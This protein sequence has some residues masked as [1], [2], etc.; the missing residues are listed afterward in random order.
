VYTVPPYL[1]VL[2]A[3]A[4]GLAQA[5]GQWRALTDDD[6]WQPAL[7]RALLAD[8]AADGHQDIGRAQIHQQFLLISFCLF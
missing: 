4:G 8:I 6:R 7:W 5:D 3:G 2:A 1:S